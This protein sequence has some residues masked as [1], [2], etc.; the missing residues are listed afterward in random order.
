MREAARL[1]SGAKRPMIVVGSGALD[2][3]EEIL[4]VAERLQ[5]PIMAKRKGKGI[6]S[7]E[8]YLSQNLPAGHR[9]WGDADAVLAVGTRLK[10]PL[11]MWGK[12]DD[13]KLVRVDIDPDELTRIC[14]PEVGIHGDDVGDRE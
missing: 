1:L 11:T 14:A 9:L 4:A 13:L 2:A 10:M 8:H 7:D 3:G 12:D 5:A 6:I